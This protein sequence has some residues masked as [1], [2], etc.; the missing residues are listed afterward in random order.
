[1]GV[2]EKRIEDLLGRIDEL[3]RILKF[4][5]DDLSEISRTL[6]SSLGSYVSTQGTGPSGALKP[7][8]SAQQTITFEEPSTPQSIPSETIT[9]E[10]VQNLFPPDLA[11][12]LYFEEADEYI[13][14][15]PRQYL[16]SDNFRRIA[17]IIRDQLGG[18]YISAGRDS[19]FRIPKA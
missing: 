1:M 9:I 7:P 4:L 14:V 3:I 10:S 11:V 15:K 6:R 8:V 17:S 12:L 19:H 13:L 2:N 18:E 16:G 5:S